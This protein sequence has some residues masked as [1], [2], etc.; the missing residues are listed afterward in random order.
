MDDIFG[1]LI[2]STYSRVREP[3]PGH[4]VCTPQYL[5]TVPARCH[6]L[7][8]RFSSQSAASPHTQG[9]L[10]GHTWYHTTP[11]LARIDGF[12]SFFLLHTLCYKLTRL[13]THEELQNRKHA[14]VSQRESIPSATRE[15]VSYYHLGSHRLFSHLAVSVRS[16]RMLVLAYSH[17]PAVVHVH[18]MVSLNG[19]IITSM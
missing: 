12:G 5:S 18:Y 4:C 7:R 15:A 6:T 9:Y 3:V 8:G 16:D 1:N 13:T 10:T 11:S 14:R 2:S 17:G 19:N